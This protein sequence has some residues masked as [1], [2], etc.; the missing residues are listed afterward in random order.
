M[1]TRYCIPSTHICVLGIVHTKA[2][3][4]MI[5]MQS[6]GEAVEFRKGFLSKVCVMCIS[7]SGILDAS[8]LS[9]FV[10]EIMY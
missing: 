8:R 3:D 5:T 10:L 7:V 9:S 6:D 4:P 1:R 2:H